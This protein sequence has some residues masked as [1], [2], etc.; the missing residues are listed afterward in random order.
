MEQHG[1]WFTQRSLAVLSYCLKLQ[2]MLGILAS[3]LV[4]CTFAMTS[5]RTLRVTAICSNVCFMSYAWLSKLWPIL[6][7]HS[8][9]L[10]L[11]LL[12]LAQA[13]EPTRRAQTAQPTGA[14]GLAARTLLLC[15][16]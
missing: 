6:V 14:S 1:V 11:N 16:G 2:N 15:P 12:R 10:P 9:L 4:L 13:G 5:M 7:L 8:M 3:F